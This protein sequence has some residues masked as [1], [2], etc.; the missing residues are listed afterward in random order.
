MEI[1]SGVRLGLPEAGDPVA[2]FPLTA[3]LEDF[4]AL[5]ALHNI[6]L[7]AQ[8]GRRAETAML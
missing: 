1:N 5:K 8:I 3:L 4:D 6:A 2:I 7:A